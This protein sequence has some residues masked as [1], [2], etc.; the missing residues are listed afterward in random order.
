MGQLVGSAALA[1]KQ[2][3]KRKELHING[4]LLP[5]HSNL[6]G[7]TAPYGLSE[8]FPRVTPLPLEYIPTGD[9]SCYV[10]SITQH[11]ALMRPP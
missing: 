7:G 6:A 9:T 2:T 4:D 8:S 10:L 1:S 5:L 3:H 11:T